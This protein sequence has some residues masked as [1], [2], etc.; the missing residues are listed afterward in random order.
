MTHYQLHFLIPTN[1]S[2]TDVWRTARRKDGE[3]GGTSRETNM[4]IRNDDALEVGMQ[5]FCQGK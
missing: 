4:T 5:A 2:F 1:S 3:I